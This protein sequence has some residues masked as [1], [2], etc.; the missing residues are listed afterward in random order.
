MSAVVIKQISGWST[1][2][3]GTAQLHLKIQ[4]DGHGY[5]LIAEEANGGYCLDC[6]HPSLAKAEKTARDQFG[7]NPG[8]W[9]YVAVS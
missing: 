3:V 8:D 4:F 7:I 1:Q 2:V 9:E 5:W 6:W